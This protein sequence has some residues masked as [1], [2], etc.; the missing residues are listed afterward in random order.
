VKICGITRSQDATVCAEAGADAIGLVFYSQ[1]PRA[2]SLPQAVEIV[3]HLPAFVTTVGLFVNAHLDEVTEVLNNVKLDCLQFHGNEDVA[4]CEQFDR[5][6]IKAVRMADDAD[7]ER[8]ADEYSSAKA[9]LLDTYVVDVPGGTGQSFNWE[10]VPQTCS[11]PIIL[12]GGLTP[13][14]VADAILVA[15]PYAVDV[16]GGVELSKGIKDADKVKKFIE[17]VE[18]L[19]A[20]K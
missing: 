11:K 4:Y 18:C 1:S 19:G 7:V 20:S 3:D 14:N 2:V 17:E 15:N 5:P 8:L 10:R 9:L 13:E 16:S 6:Y 12:A